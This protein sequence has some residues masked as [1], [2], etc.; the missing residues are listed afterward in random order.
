[1]ATIIDRPAAGAAPSL[2]DAS[3]RNHV[4]ARLD[5]LVLE[6]LLPHVSPTS[7]KFGQRLVAAEQPLTHAYFPESGVISLVANLSDGNTLEVG[8][9]GPEGMV[10]ANVVLGLDW[11]P[12][13]AIVQVAGTALSV[14]VDVLQAEAARTPELRTFLSR[15]VQYELVSAMQTAV[16]NNF[17]PVE[18]RCARWLLQVLDLTGGPLTISQEFL[19]QMLGVR[20]P[21]VTLLLGSFERAGLI[22]CGRRRIDVR[23]R[24]N[25]EK[26]SCECYD[27]LRQTHRKL[28]I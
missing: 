14:R 23:D 18:S 13:G 2:L 5:R 21:T 3:P 6:R 15:H 10:G 19:A 1:M 11:M 7:L 16:C 28:A 20:R 27:S 24:T 25:L 26:L 8:M 22:I 12:C 17:H 4:L 9:I